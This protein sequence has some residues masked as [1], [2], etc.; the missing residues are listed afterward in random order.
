MSD[1]EPFDL[2]A[3]TTHLPEH[4]FDAG[5]VIVEEGRHGGEIWILVDGALNISKGGM[6]VNRVSHPGSTLGEISVLLSAPHSATVEAAVPSILR[7][8]AD[9]RAL[10]RSDPAISHLI[11][12]TL[13]ER[14][15]FVTTYLSDLQHQYGNAAGL[16]MVKDVLAQLEQRRGPRAVP[17]S[18]REPDPSY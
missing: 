11:A 13:A 5:A 14:L 15:S 16:T 9:G 8:A 6:V 4:R 7:L 10:L 1:P 18:A 2:L 3:R 12:V 17:G